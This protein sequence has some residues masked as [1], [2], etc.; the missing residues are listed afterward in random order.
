MVVYGTISAVDCSTL[1]LKVALDHHPFVVYNITE[2][3]FLVKKNAI[4]YYIFILIIHHIF[5]C[6]GSIKTLMDYDVKSTKDALS[7][8]CSKNVI[9]LYINTSKQT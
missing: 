1:L 5:Y 2:I 8:T 4:I 9:N 7:S 3:F 6:L